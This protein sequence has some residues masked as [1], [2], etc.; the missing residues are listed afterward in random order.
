MVTRL[1]QGRT[2]LIVEDELRLLVQAEQ[3]M[4]QDRGSGSHQRK[5]NG[6]EQVL[7]GE[8]FVFFS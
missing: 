7:H 1:N 8:H 4:E 2:R 6:F 3:V 5:A